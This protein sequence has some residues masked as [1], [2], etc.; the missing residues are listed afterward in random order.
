[1]Q[2][3]SSCIKFKVLKVLD[4]LCAYV[5]DCDWEDYQQLKPM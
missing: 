4:D 2:L 3:S 1:M 5:Y